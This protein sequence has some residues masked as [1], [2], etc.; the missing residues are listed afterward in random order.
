MKILLVDRLEG[1]DRDILVTDD[2]GPN[3]FHVITHLFGQW[4][5]E[6]PM[7][8]NGLKLFVVPGNNLIQVH[9]KI[10]YG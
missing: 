3:L 5:R 7:V 4:T 2:T 9:G 8:S 1:D 10:W 6:G